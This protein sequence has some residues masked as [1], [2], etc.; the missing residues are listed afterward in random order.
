ML[1]AQIR[2]LDHPQDAENVY[3]AGLHIDVV[4]LAEGRVART[5][6]AHRLGNLANEMV[7]LIRKNQGLWQTDALFTECWETAIAAAT[8]S[9]PAPP[10]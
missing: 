4:A 6:V 9:A 8:G 5:D 7:T 1:R 3:A 10:R 2:T